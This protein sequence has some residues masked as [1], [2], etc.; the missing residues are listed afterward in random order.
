MSYRKSIVRCDINNKNI[1]NLKR[2]RKKKRNEENK[3]IKR[4]PESNAEQH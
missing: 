1:Q 4:K 2:K 3:E